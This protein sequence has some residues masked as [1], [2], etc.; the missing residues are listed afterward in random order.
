MIR[1]AICLSILLGCGCDKRRQAPTTF[2]V[3]DESQYVLIILLDLS[4]SFHQQMT[5]GGQAHRFSMQVIDHYFRERIGTNDKLIIAQISGEERALLWEGTPLQLQKDFPSSTA[6][7]EFLRSKAN[8][9]ASLVYEAIIHTIDYVLSDPSVSSGNAKSAIFVL[10]DMSDN[11]SKPESKQ[12]A[13]QALAAYGESGGV[14]G[15]YYV[16]QLLVP[17]WRTI[18]RDAGIPEICVESDIVGRPNLPNFE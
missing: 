15:L 4:G 6:F 13:L 11:G 3:R 9:D 18:L 14:V 17:E 12:R 16:D 1:L 2:A 8:P 7:G 10:S 5:E